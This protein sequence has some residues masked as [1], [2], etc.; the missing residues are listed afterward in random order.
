VSGQRALEQGDDAIAGMSSGRP[1]GVPP[2]DGVPAARG[3]GR[4]AIKR[5]ELAGARRDRGV[6]D[7]AQDA[8]RVGE[9]ALA[10]R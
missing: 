4:P 10:G 5:R 1:P 6:V 7:G 2:Q 8:P 9:E 3:L